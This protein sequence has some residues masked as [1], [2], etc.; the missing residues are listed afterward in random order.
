L[1]VLD[2]PGQKFTRQLMIAIVDGLDGFL[3]SFIIRH[4]DNLARV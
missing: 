4:M 3:K 2:Q 1:I